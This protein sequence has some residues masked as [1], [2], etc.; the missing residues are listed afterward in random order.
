MNTENISRYEM[1]RTNDVIP[2]YITCG[3]TRRST[4]LHAHK[5]YELE[6]VLEGTATHIINGK[7]YEIGR[8]NTYILSPMDFHSYELH[9]PLKAYC[10]NFDTSIV[11]PKMISKI[12]SIDKTKPIILSEEAI[13][14]ASAIGNVL[15]KE[16]RKADGGC[17]VELCECFL[18]II[19]A[20][21]DATDKSVTS[22]QDTGIQRAIAY[23]NTH[24]F[25]DPTLEEV[26][27]AA[28]YNPSYFSD[29]F[30][31]HIGESFVSRLNNLRIEYSKVL[32]SNGARVID[33]C[34][35]SGFRSISTFLTVFKKH[36]G[37]SPNEYKKRRNS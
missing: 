13:Q 22:V 9:S 3:C 6:L 23:L 7:R 5:Y 28:G 16:S 25:E 32:L 24:F 26:A 34:F 14:D 33:A 15:M 4:P 11:S 37:I 17:S 30:K 10:L 27:N 8:G 36:T 18:S 1:H 31:K 21:I 35:D 19:F 2:V 12:F 20:N 29:I